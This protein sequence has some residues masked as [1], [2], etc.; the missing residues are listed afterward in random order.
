[1]AVLCGTFLWK[2]VH[3][4][5]Q[6]GTLSWLPKVQDIVSKVSRSSTFYAFLGLSI[7][8]PRFCD[9]L[10]LLAWAWYLTS[11]WP[12]Y[13]QISEIGVYQC[14]NV[15]T[16]N[17]T[18]RAPIIPWDIDLI[19]Q[20]KDATWIVVPYNYFF[21]YKFEIYEFGLEICY[22][23]RTWNHQVEE[24]QGHDLQFLTIE[25]FYAFDILVLGNRII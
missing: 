24:A 21:F 9:T 2:G 22:Y 10:Y 13:R 25:V 19:C 18:C 17:D 23:N 1:M 11:F 4:Y 5:F 16:M 7:N 3:S 8:L 15:L 14:Y 6:L 12:C 20:F